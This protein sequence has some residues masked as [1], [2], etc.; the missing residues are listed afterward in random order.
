MFGRVWLK[1]ISFTLLAVMA[2]LLAVATI[3]E[4]LKGTP[5]VQ[6]Y[7]YHS[8]VFVSLWGALTAFSL[9]YIFKSKSYKKPFTLLIHLALVVILSGA[10]TTFLSGKKGLVHLRQGESQNSYE[11]E[12]GEKGQFPFSLRLVKFKLNYYT[13][14]QTPQDFISQLNISFDGKSE[15][16][17]VSM[18][19][20]LNFKGYR[21]FQSGYDED[22]QG[23]HLSV[24]YDPYGTGIT[25]FGYGLLLCSLILFF[26]SRRSEFY[27]LIRSPLLKGGLIIL[28]FCGV[29]TQSFAKDNKPLRALTQEQAEDF[30]DLYLLYN[31]RVCPMQTLA[32]DFTLKL[33]GKDHYKGY[34]AEQV[35]TG[36][37]FY[38]GDWA[39]EPMIKVDSRA[40][41]K[42][43]GISDS[44]TS[45]VNFFDQRRRY[46][47]LDEM[48]KLYQGLEVLDKKGIRQADD[49][50]NIIAM[51]RMGQLTKLF[52]YKDKSGLIH[53]YAP[54]G[55][56]PKDLIQ[57]KRLF[58]NK[59]I[60]YLLDLVHKGEY[61][62]FSNFCKKIKRYQLKE[63][64]LEALPSDTRFQAEKLYN[65]LDYSGLLFKLSL[66]IGLLAFF[67]FIYCL[68]KSQSP[69]RLILYVL[70][71]CLILLFAYLTL[72]I[73]L[74]AYVSGH[75][76]TTNGYET[77]QFLAWAA[78]LGSFFLQFKFRIVLPF[79]FLLAGLS[80]L[81][82]SLG[83]SSPQI[84]SLMPVLASPL[85]SIHVATIMIAYLLFA[86]MMFNGLAALLL[87]VI[88]DNTKAIKQLQ[89]VSQI[90]LYPG[91]FLLSIG[92]FIG[93]IWANV[94]W[95]RYWGWD[96]KEVWAL[97]TMLI[98]SFPIHT[99]SLK[100]FQR[101]L[102]FHVFVILAFFSVLFTYFG[103]NYLL[104]GLHSYANS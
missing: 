23:T 87:N 55:E 93:A 59:G 5:F 101:P 10:L 45:F 54:N 49:K 19:K 14:T 20:V 78:L 1:R 17:E 63:V 40:V 103:V 76:P 32:K 3:I 39:C 53:W 80:L 15:S 11:T 64:G 81:V 8:A 9:F 90:L 95:G 2:I 48:S 71:L 21:F 30:C 50:Y 102:F 86:F 62:E 92:T 85:L 7:I 56:L 35:F 13:G 12:Q 96:P 36:W 79:G 104:S 61:T 42:I 33:Y 77:M 99:K 16:F 24:S 73:G 83:Q 34:T 6:N 38:Y 89:I 37:L 28:L 94:S 44:Y 68:V 65:R 4:E 74:R 84:S 75:F 69:R 98:Y 26:F 100:S 72:F 46:K 70:N 43:L 57:D 31:G 52:P 91:L 67:Y 51:L 58:F 27:K 18:N 22:V 82:A 66:F 25:Y 47:L 60:G 41:Q 88:G 29:D 97:I